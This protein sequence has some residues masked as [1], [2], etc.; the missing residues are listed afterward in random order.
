MPS[1]SE[2][3]LSSIDRVYLARA[4]ELAARGIGNTAPNPPVGAVVV[5]DG[6]TAGEGF[7]HRA[8]EEHAETLA[9]EQAGEAAAGATLYV[10]LEPCAVPGRVPACAPRVR[11][12]GIARVV[13]G[14]TDPNPTNSGLGVTMLRE[15][16]LEVVVANDP[17]AGDV[18]QIFAG[19]LRTDRPYVA[20]KLAVSL[21]GM[22]AS[23]PGVR[24]LLS[25]AEEL[26]FV[27]DLR[28]AYDAVLVGSNTVRVDD[29][30]L[31]VRPPHLRLRP[32]VRV[33]ACRTETLDESSR[34]FEPVDNYNR[35]VV[36]VPAGRREGFDN[37]D[38]AADVVAVGKTDSHDL[39]IASAMGALRAAGVTS[40]L[41]E[42]GPALAGAML[43][44]GVV[45]RFYWSVAPRLLSN[46]RSVP[47][48]RG[49]D[50]SD[51]PRALRF[52][53]PRLLG[54]DALISGTFQDV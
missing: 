19:S 18:I 20:L 6:R 36:L 46:D 16:G 21:D 35:T 25:G 11:D 50:L 32:F 30:L 17:V 1:T 41:C 5:R 44:A 51:A 38:R 34:V 54:R 24:E 43:R 8:G 14:T 9:I 37:L 40:V 53:P 26:R 10:T 28:V 27:R 33:V 52:D 47:A 7:H 49:V 12:A 3:L 39:D 45:D 4:C 29:P 2:Q 23:R 22:V 13:I 42:G 15:A 31:T 48:V